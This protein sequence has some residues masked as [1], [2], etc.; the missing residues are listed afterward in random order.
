MASKNNKV[1]Y[2]LKN[3]YYAVATIAEDGSAT[4]AKP[5]VRWPGAVSLS[6]DAEGEPTNF[7]A[8]NGVYYTV[9]NNSGYTGDYE[10]A[11][12]PES[13][14]TEV[15]GDVKD[16]KGILFENASAQSVHFALLFE[17]EGD[18]NAIRHVLYNCTASRP[19]IES[20]TK[21]DEVEVQTETL[22]ITA[23]P[24]Y[25]PNLKIYTPKA[26]CELSETNTEEYNNWFTT[27]YVPTAS[28]AA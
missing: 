4:Y 23:S 9:N 7:Y 1:K 16:E 15:L 17:F 19:T 5:P 28:E 26:K 21:E 20:A 25:I 8:D 27:V 12:V 2:G 3:V 18:V 13:F 10:S 6:L 24:I 14:R 11:M 22:S